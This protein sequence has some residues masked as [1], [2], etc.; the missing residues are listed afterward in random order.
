ME[1]AIYCQYF[2]SSPS[3]SSKTINSILFLRQH[4]YNK[5]YTL[6]VEIKNTLKQGRIMVP[7]GL[8]PRLENDCEPTRR[9]IYAIFTLV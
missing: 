2:C 5:A 6:R 4:R 3:S 8:A 7:L 1:K 9:K